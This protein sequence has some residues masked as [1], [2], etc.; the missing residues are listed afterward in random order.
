MNMC[1]WMVDDARK[2]TKVPKITESNK[3]QEDVESRDHNEMKS[4]M[5]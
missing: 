2:M 4:Q 1:E 3:R 5:R